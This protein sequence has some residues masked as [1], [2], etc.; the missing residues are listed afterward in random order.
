MMIQ[1]R[2]IM[3]TFSEVVCQSESANNLAACAM[4]THA[5]LQTGE[6]KYLSHHPGN[7]I[8]VYSSVRRESGL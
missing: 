6:Q 3:K 4:V 7:V 2:Y 8:H 1:N 5:Y